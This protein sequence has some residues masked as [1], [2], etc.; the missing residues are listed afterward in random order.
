V[1]DLSRRDFL[2]RSALL[3]GGVGLG[4]TVA[5]RTLSG[6]SPTG[7]SRYNAEFAG[8]KAD[9]IAVTDAD[10]GQT[11]PGAVHIPSG[12]RVVRLT[13][14]PTPFTVTARCSY[15]K[16]DDID[17]SFGNAS[18][19]VG[20][21]GHAATIGPKHY[22]LQHDIAYLGEIGIVDGLWG[23]YADTPTHLRP[24]VKLGG[25]EWERP[26][27][28]RMVVHSGTNI[29]TSY[30]WDGRNWTTYATG[31]NPNVDVEAVLLLSYACTTEWDWVRFT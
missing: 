16:Y 8:P 3:A 28:Q 24:Y 5:E 12:N 13:V 4:L 15:L 20:G 26:H 23:Q 31:T 9:W 25:L 21:A 30:S 27:Y 18:L 11:T 10:F 14:P 2:R 22:A 29:D 17:R 7:M 19:A 1:V 6:G